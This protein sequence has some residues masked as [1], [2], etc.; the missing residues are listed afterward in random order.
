MTWINQREEKRKKRKR[1]RGQKSKFRL[2]TSN[3][4]TRH[5]CIEIFT[6]TKPRRKSICFIFIFHSNEEKLNNTH[7]ELIYAKQCYLIELKHQHFMLNTCF[8][9]S[10]QKFIISIS[11]S[12]RSLATEC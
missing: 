9:F 3:N 2:T 5:T 11:K 7:Y 10:T 1:E 8:I 6:T 12:I 4:Y